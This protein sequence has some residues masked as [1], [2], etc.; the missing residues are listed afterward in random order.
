MNRILTYDLYTVLSILREEGWDT[1]NSALLEFLA[2]LTGWVPD[3]EIDGYIRHHKRLRKVD[4]MPWSKQDSA[5][6]REDLIGWRDA[7]CRRPAVALERLTEKSSD[8]VQQG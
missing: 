5:D 6:L 4:H 1:M 3:E 2:D 7:Y 8:P